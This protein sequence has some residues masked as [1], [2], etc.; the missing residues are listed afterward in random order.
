MIVT[1]ADCA[2]RALIAGALLCLA[3]SAAAAADPGYCAAYARQAVHDAQVMSTLS[4]FRGFDSRWSADYD[5]HYEWCLPVAGET[6]AGEQAYRRRR[7][8]QCGYRG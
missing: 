3:A 8:L 4:C 2:A 5:L 1:V 7:L 6:S